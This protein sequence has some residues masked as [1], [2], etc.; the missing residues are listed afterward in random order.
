MKLP[1]YRF[2]YDRRHVASSERKGA[3]EF[4]ISYN[5]KQKR[6]AT[7]MLVYPQN[8]NEKLSKVIK[9]DNAVEMNKQ[10]ALFL[11]NAETVIYTMIKEE[12]FDMDALASVLQK[13]DGDINMNFAQYVRACAE[14]KNVRESTKKRYD[15]FLSV[16]N[17]Y[18]PTIFFRDINVRFIKDYDHWLHNRNIGTEK[19]PRYMMQ[20]TIATHHKY[21]KQFIA[22]AVI[23]KYIASN[24]Y[25]EK[26]IHIDKGEKEQVDYITEAQLKNLMGLELDTDYL[27]RARDLFVFSA[28]TG[29]SYSDVMTFNKENIVKE[30]KNFVYTDRRFKN[31]IQYTII[32]LP[33]ALKILKKYNYELPNITNQKLNL[34]LKV[35]GQMIGEPKLHAHQARGTFATIA[36]NKGIPADVLRRMLGHKKSIM[37]LHYASVLNDTITSEMEK[38]K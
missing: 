32:L 3:I 18:N 17:E 1:K 37:T 19:N 16:L 5:Y 12:R 10:L 21:M 9:L 33:E 27:D 15:C 13:K 8:W 35:L 22:E 28:Y 20:A 2:I 30:G 29:L 6:I 11:D 23:D 36:L 7:G 38:M 34:Y 24:P 14:K 31:N 26:A 25:H 4:E